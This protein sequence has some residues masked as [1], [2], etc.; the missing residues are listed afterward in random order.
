MVP[1]AVG[2]HLDI[3]LKSEDENALQRLYT[4]AFVVGAL[5]FAL[6]YFVRPVMF[7]VMPALIGIIPVWMVIG[8]WV[9]WRAREPAETSSDVF[10]GAVAFVVA[11]VVAVMVGRDPDEWFP[12][13]PVVAAIASTLAIVQ[14][15]YEW[16]AR[17]YAND[18]PIARFS[19]KAAAGH[20]A[21]YAFGLTL[22]IAAAI[23]VRTRFELEDEWFWSGSAYG[24]AFAFGKLF[25]DMLTPVPAR[26]RM[27]TLSGALIRMTV[28]SPLWWGLPWGIAYA[29]YAVFSFPMW[30]SWEFMLREAVLRTLHVAAAVTLVFAALTILVYAQELFLKRPSNAMAV[31]PAA[32]DAAGD[33]ARMFWG[34]VLVSIAAGLWIYEPVSPSSRELFGVETWKCAK[35]EDDY[36]LGWIGSE[37]VH[38]TIHR[39]TV[40]FFNLTCIPRDTFRGG[41]KYDKEVWD[42]VTFTITGP[43]GAKS[44]SFKR[45]SAD[46]H[47]GVLH[48]KTASELLDAFYKGTS[49]DLIVKAPK[50]RVMYVRPINLNGFRVELDKCVLHWRRSSSPQR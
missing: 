32:Q 13:V 48:G 34:L 49:A 50:G 29:G 44:V 9:G 7:L 38:I 10:I 45:D 14:F 11:A 28:V 4:A 35:E 16:R 1:N 36:N 31:A 20:F 40:D 23:V 15:A 41:C 25:A 43:S 27:P 39:G 42:E 26:F 37:G 24:I 18:G 3:R 47:R 21:G 33:W 6:I 19:R 5:L 46:M 17:R 12:I 30:L 2:V 22:G 8:H